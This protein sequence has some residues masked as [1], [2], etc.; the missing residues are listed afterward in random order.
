MTTT[1]PAS[2]RDRFRLAA[3][4]AHRREYLSD[5]T[6]LDIAQAWSTSDLDADCTATDA[7]GLCMSEVCT[8]HSDYCTMREELFDFVASLTMH[9]EDER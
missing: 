9:P 7:H 6:L 3:E 5:D 1:A 4:D 2:F 8:T